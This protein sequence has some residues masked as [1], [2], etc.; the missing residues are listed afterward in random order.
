MNELE[1]VQAVS[2]SVSSPAEATSAPTLSAPI[3]P[4]QIAE[5]NGA[6]FADLIGDNLEV[7]ESRI[8]RANTLV[9]RFAVDDTVPIHQ[10]TMALGRARLGVELATQMR[11]QLV[12]SYRQVMNMQI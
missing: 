6:S 2:A 1:A 5:P 7:L 8:D 4:A 3:Q 11:T 10:V 9:Q 12:E